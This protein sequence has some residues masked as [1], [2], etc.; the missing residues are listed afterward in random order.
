MARQIQLA[1]GRTSEVECLS[2]AVANGV[3]EPTG[4]VVLE[5]RHFHAHQDLAYPISLRPVRCCTPVTT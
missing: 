3:I 5:T 1:D 2:C 4:G